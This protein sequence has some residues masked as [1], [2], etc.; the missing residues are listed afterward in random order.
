MF[1]RW[2]GSVSSVEDVEFTDSGSSSEEEPELTV[3]QSSPAMRYLL[4]KKKIAVYR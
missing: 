2:L 3:P 1:R 4:V